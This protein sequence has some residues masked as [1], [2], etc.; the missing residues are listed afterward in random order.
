MKDFIK[1]TA[2]GHSSEGKG[3]KTNCGVSAL[4]LLVREA[5][6]VQYVLEIIGYLE[7]W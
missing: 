6:P 2:T 1:I 3:K 4:I 5:A 7:H